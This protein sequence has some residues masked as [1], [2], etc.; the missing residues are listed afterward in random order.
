MYKIDENLKSSKDGYVSIAK[1]IR[2]EAYTESDFLEQEGLPFYFI[3]YKDLNDVIPVSK[4]Y[5]S[6]TLK[7]GTFPTSMVIYKEKK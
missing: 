7:V 5:I 4:T 3:N 6:D 1:Y 2:N